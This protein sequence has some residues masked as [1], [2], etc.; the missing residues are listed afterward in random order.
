MGDAMTEEAPDEAGARRSALIAERDRFIGFAFAAAHLLMEVDANG[1]ILFAIGAR[2]K[3]AAKD[4]S[5][6]VGFN[7]FDIV[8]PEDWSYVREL[9]ERLK[10]QMRIN[11]SRV[12]FRTFEGQYFS[13]LLGGCCLPS[14]PGRFYLSVLLSAPAREADRGGRGSV[15]LDRKGF[16]EILEDR[17][18]AS[19]RKGLDRNLTLLL[20]DGFADMT[21]ETSPEAARL[22]MTGL[23]AYL[24]SVSA[25]GDSA[26][27]LADDRFGVIHATDVSESDIQSNVSRILEASGVDDAGQHIRTWGLTLDDA[28]LDPADAARALVY[29]VQTFATASE[30]EF[31]ISTLEDGARMML[32][33]TVQRITLLRQ[34][35]EQ[36]DFYVVYQPIVDIATR[37]LH[38]LE[39]LTRLEGVASPQEFILFAES[40]GMIYDFDLLLT[41]TVLETMKEYAHSPHLPAVAIN[42]SAR[43]LTSP[44]F[45]EQFRR[46]VGAFGDLG[47]KLMVEVTESVSVGDFES[48]NATLQKLRQAGHRVCL[49]DVGSGST[50]FQSLHGLQVDVAK[51]DG[52]FVRGALKRPRDMTIL[53][54]I[55]ETCMHLDLELVG[56]QIEDTEQADLLAGLGV[57]YGQGYLYGR[58]TRDFAFFAKAAR[59]SA[60]PKRT[61]LR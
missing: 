29:T 1:A 54:S 6:L 49:D 48:L 17:L 21:D 15:M 10:Q 30:G 42:L 24:R 40:V 9:L 3:L 7:F 35:I 12:V 22:M 43:T 44:V 19:R 46:I 14:Y 50:S 26:G 41:Q 58:P 20:I 33:R 31:S 36:R 18:V 25:D 39:A 38:H 51:I 53:K 45:L 37:K 52:Q 59:R 32:D 4:I 11:P 5:E 16:T 8:A 34:T 60:P 28:H 2:C 27:R 13:A 56:E 61:T 23:D 57:T 55:A 47:R